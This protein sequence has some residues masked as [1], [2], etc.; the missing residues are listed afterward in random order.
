ML[1]L[2]RSI[3]LT[4]LT[5]DTEYI[6]TINPLN[7]GGDVMSENELLGVTPPLDTPKGTAGISS[8]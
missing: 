4:P 5:A 3:T 2:S 7:S 8:L 6:I 1:F